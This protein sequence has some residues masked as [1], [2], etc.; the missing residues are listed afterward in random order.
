MYS[1]RAILKLVECVYDVAGNPEHW[2]A[3]LE[4]FKRNLNS[5]AVTFFMQDLRGQGMS[6]VASVGI[7]PS[8]V[9]SY[10]EHYAA[11][12]VYLFRRKHLLFTGNVCSSE[13]LCPDR[14]ARRSE[15]YNEWIEPQNQ[16]HGLMGVLF[17]P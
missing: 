5:K 3:F 8:Y 6:T 14:E 4:S 17:S 10:E 12:N 15:F 13:M 11:K 9:R 16:G 1:E 7:E 2:P